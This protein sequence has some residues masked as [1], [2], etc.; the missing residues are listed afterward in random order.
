M[1]EVESVRRVT[2]DLEKCKGTLRQSLDCLNSGKDTTAF[3]HLWTSVDMIVRYLESIPTLNFPASTL[4][5]STPET[6]AIYITEEVL[7]ENLPLTGKGFSRQ[8][9]I[10]I[11][12]ALVEVEIIEGDAN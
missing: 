9:A 2:P 5:A 6:N 8:L 3:A 4:T 12:S 11:V 7:K 1:G 10:K